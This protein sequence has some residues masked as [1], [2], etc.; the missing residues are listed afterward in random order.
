VDLANTEIIVINNASQDD[1]KAVLTYFDGFI[2]VLNNDENLGFV[3][4]NNKGA[5]LAR[6]KYLVFLNNDTVVLPGWLEQMVKTAEEDPQ[7]GVVGPM[8]I[9]PDWTL[10]EAGCIL[11][12]NA[13]AY[14]YGWGRSPDDRRYRFAREV[15]YITGASLLIRKDLWDRLGGFDTRYAPIYYEDA[16]LCMGVRSLGFKVIYQPGSRILHFEGATTGTDERFGLKRFQVI[17]RNKFHDKW[18]EVLERDHYPYDPAQAERAANRQ[19][20][21]QIIVFDDRIPM[22][23]RDAGSARMLLILKTLAKMGPVTFVSLGNLSVPEYE[24]ELT[25]AGVEII[26]VVEYRRLFERREF[27]V[28]IMSRADVA[29]ALMRSIKRTGRKI[30]TIFDTVDLNFVR[31]ERE[32]H[33]TQDKKMAR[34]AKRYLKV[35]TRLAQ[36][37]D[38]VWCVTETDAD[39][40]ARVAPAAEVA[41]IPTIHPLQERGGP[42]AERS[43]LVFI[44]NY[45]HRPNVDAVHFFM[46]EIFPLVQ[47]SIPDICVNIV[48]AY[49]PAEFASYKS[50]E[51]NLMGHVANVDPI[52]QRCRAFVAPLRFGSG[53]KGKIGQALSY[54]LPVVTTTVGAEGMELENEQNVLIADDAESFSK[55]VIRLYQD[56][57]LWQRLSDNGYHHIANNFTPEIVG[58]KIRRA[59]HAV[60]GINDQ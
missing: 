45:L 11:W 5:A 10:Q 39:A 31:I 17:N 15:D 38:Q 52:F 24:A 40:L 2:R 58:E 49:A 29:G 30:K 54:G 41:V 57:E 36:S 28:A 55:S 34:A 9:Y 51:A 42:F 27:E 33:V 18:R 1:T 13:Q 19:R 7:V 60:R 35:E 25:R 50:S 3:L 8:F 32:Y 14:R 16:D 53:M 44:G 59:I 21:M 23:D 12:S 56:G 22:P 6:G 37:C 26:P 43:G 20:G 47:Q 4:G 48:G 46:R